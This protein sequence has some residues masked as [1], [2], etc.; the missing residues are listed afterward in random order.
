M[1]HSVCAWGSCPWTGLWI[2]P[3][4][5]GGDAGGDVGGAEGFADFGLAGK[6]GELAEGDAAGPEPVDVLAA[7]SVER[8]EEGGEAAVLLL[9]EAGMGGIGVGAGSRGTDCHRCARG[10]EKKGAILG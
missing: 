9:L 5:A 1:G 7:Y 6:D 4:E 2:G 3:G 8:G 10:G